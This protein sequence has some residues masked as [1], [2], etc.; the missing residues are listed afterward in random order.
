MNRQALRDNL[1]LAATVTLVN[2]FSSLTGLPFALYASLAVL[3]VTVGN[4]GNTL[5][6]GRQRLIG[7]AVGAGVVFFGYRAWGHLPVV[8]ALPLALLLARLIAGS[9]RLTVGYSVCCF[10]VVM[11]WLTHDQQ[12]DSWIPLRLLWTAFGILIALLSLRLFWPSRARIQQREGLL[13]LLANLGHTLQAIAGRHADAME[14]QEQWRKRLGLRLKHLRTS[15]L[16]L[17]EQRQGALV[18]LGPLAGQHPLA[19]L[20]EL[21]DQACEALILDLDELRRLPASEWQAWGLQDTAA[22]AD[23]FVA[24]VAERL[25]GWQERLRQPLQLQP[26]PSESRPPLPMQA[27]QTP[28]EAAALQQLNPAQ[29]QRVASR[30]MVLNRIDHTLASTEEQW[31]DLVA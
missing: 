24:G 5:E 3:S 21:L 26:P 14:P 11:G 17:R 28:E 15:L 31:L 29:L 2:G 25:L 6:L 30:L 10:V 12:L 4:Y 9:L 23:R 8:V 7:T 1:R 22:A 18:E 16:G 13:Q 20:W 19:R 27:L